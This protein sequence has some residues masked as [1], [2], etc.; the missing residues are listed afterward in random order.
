MCSRF[1]RTKS[2]PSKQQAGESIDQSKNEK[3]HRSL[4]MEQDILE[5]E[6]RV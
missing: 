6:H 1:G 3:R 5:S 2:F 4:H